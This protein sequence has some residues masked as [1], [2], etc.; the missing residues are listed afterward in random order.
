[1]IILRAF[2][3]LCFLSLPLLVLSQDG[4]F[5][6]LS[7]E[8]TGV[9][10]SSTDLNTTTPTTESPPITSEEILP[11]S[12]I[13]ETP[14]E[15]TTPPSEEI[16][17]D[18]PP[19]QEEETQTVSTQKPTEENTSTRTT[20]IV[21]DEEIAP[22][23][24][25]TKNKKKND[26]VSPDTYVQQNERYKLPE[27]YK[28]LDLNTAIEQ[29][30]RE[31]GSEKIRNLKSD[32]IEINKQSAYTAFWLPNVKLQLSTEEQRL[33]RAWKGKK[34]G[35]GASASPTGTFGLSFGDYTIFNWGKDYLK[36][37]N[38]TAELKRSKE[39]LYEE[40]RM[41]RHKV[42]SSYFELVTAKN[43]EKVMRNHL[44]QASFIFRLNKEK[45]S[46]GKATR[47]EYYESR[48]QYLKAQSDFQEAAVK[49]E[50]IEEALNNLINDPHGTSYITNQDI[51]FQKVTLPLDEALGIAKVKNANIL[52]AKTK[53]KIAE[54]NYLLSAKESLPLPKISVNLGAYTNSF[55][56]NGNVTT[57][58]TRPNNSD[59][60][61]VATVNATWDIVGPRGLLNSKEREKAYLEKEISI[62]SLTQTKDDADS[63]V[64][65]LYKRVLFYE[66]Q[67]ILLEARSNNLQKNFDILLD[68]YVN[69]R[70]YLNDLR[71]ALDELVETQA[72]F[73]QTKLE[74]IRSK[75]LLATH[76][77]ME[78]L[79]GES[80]EKLV[81]GAKK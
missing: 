20:G 35:E 33:G 62:H 77:G 40:R 25:K 38:T 30:L 28:S 56:K 2:T 39:N 70:A 55:S 79:P 72:L 80:F 66:K 4:E 18:T 44:R 74:H 60:D 7:S 13:N 52:N 12:S 22:I 64:R 19:Q 61:I 21:S 63:V 71:R 65:D 41:L 5:D 73:E 48:A 49:L 51:L 11:S 68:N 46:V 36:Y 29:G 10:S 9:N 42:I 8:D 67:Y 34:N 31:N 78:D 53:L 69:K 17:S 75:I 81:V 23:K 59:V 50:V 26:S 3:I 43:V 15:A 16:S 58:Q 47:Q 14:I 45:V 1:M 37:I 54:H 24:A 6:T 57:Y 27:N 32:L 76:M